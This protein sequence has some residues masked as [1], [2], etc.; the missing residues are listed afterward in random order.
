MLS[1]PSSRAAP[2]NLLLETM[3]A[4]M[5][6]FGSWYM[7]SLSVH[8]I[9]TKVFTAATLAMTGDLIAQSFEK[10]PYDTKRGLSFGLFDSIYRG[11]F[12]HFLFPVIDD[13]FH[14]TLLL[15]L[16]PSGD[17]GLLAALE[18]TFANQLVVRRL[19]KNPPETH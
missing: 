7:D 19:A 12:Q 4:P 6:E 9:T 10:C 15:Q 14:G 8:P 3:P 5:L 11:G 2:P 13:T 17:V 18:R 1:S 16:F